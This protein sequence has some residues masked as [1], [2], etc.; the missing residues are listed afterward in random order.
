MLV[1]CDAYST[2]LHVDL[3]SVLRLTPGCS[4]PQACRPYAAMGNEPSRSAARRD[5]AAP[6]QPTNVSA[7][8]TTGFERQKIMHRL[9]AI[10][11]L[12]FAFDGTTL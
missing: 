4:A 7:S 6:K 5:E 9:G 8:H 11:A 12:F 2:C 3:L 1:L 10:F